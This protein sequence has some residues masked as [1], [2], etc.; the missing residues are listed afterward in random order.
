ME[1]LPEEETARVILGVVEEVLSE[2]VE[3]ST[4][5]ALRN[6]AP[7]GTSPGIVNMQRL[8]F[9]AIV[10]NEIG[11]SERLGGVVR[12]LRDLVSGSVYEALMDGRLAREG[13]RVQ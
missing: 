13:V 6:V 7:S 10:L 5:E 4:D 3:Q 11:P 2:L 9:L 12:E 8:L 1:R